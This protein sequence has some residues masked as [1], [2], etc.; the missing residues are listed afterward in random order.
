MCRGARLWSGHRLRRRRRKPECRGS[1]DWAHR[2]PR[3]ELDARRSGRAARDAR[4]PAERGW[5]RRMHSSRGRRGHGRRRGVDHYARRP[6]RCVYPPG[7]TP[8]AYLGGPSL[9]SSGFHVRWTPPLTRQVRDRDPRRSRPR[10]LRQLC[11]PGPG[12]SS[13]PRT[14]GGGLV[15][16]PRLRHRRTA[17]GV[18]RVHVR[19]R[20][21]LAASRPTQRAQPTAARRGELHPRARIRRNAV[22]A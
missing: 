12:P 11:G 15:R 20:G 4:C 17:A 22:H 9:P 7:S 6:S 2:R 10:I 18:G 3:R 19:T 13:R 1:G 14:P 16:G 21:A 5:T 8:S